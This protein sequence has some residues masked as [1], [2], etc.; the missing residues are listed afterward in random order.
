MKT[1]NKIM[2]LIGR[3]RRDGQGL[4]SSPS[5][6]GMNPDGTFRYIETTLYEE[7]DLTHQLYFFVTFIA[8]ILS[9]RIL[10][11]SRLKTLSGEHILNV[12]N[13]ND[14]KLVKEVFLAYLNAAILEPVLAIG[15][16]DSGE[17]AYRIKLLANSFELFSLCW[18]IWLVSDAF[19]YDD[20]MF[21][22]K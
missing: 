16:L 15:G 4:S 6:S 8:M 3:F 19:D 18:W 2:G 14:V 9:L 20:V 10:T 1:Q 12:H 13:L 22:Y 21:Q 7:P 5:A 17:D 11:T